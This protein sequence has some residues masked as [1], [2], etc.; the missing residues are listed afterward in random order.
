MRFLSLLRLGFRP[1]IGIDIGKAPVIKKQHSPLGF[2]SFAMSFVPQ[3]TMTL[4]TPESNYDM[5][6][7]DE[8]L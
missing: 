3:Q 8:L 4:F 5:S 1:S 6:S 2:H 7:V